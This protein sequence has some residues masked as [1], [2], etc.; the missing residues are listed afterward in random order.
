[1]LGRR[2]HV[3]ADAAYHGNALRTLPTTTVTWTTRLPRN[4]VLYRPRPSHTGKCRSP[5]QAIVERVEVAT[6]LDQAAADRMP[7]AAAAW[8]AG[9]PVVRSRP[10]RRADRL[11][12]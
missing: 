5:V 4:A 9:E 6:F 12:G 7:Y 3:V 1:V 8:K 10:A 11:S 2:V